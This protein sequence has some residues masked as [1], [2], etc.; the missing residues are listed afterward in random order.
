MSTHLGAS[1]PLP[2]DL[3]ER[4]AEVLEEYLSELEAG[5]Q[6]DREQL[7]TAHPELAEAL[8]ASL[9]GLQF[10]H[11]AVAEMTQ[12]GGLPPILGS[13]SQKQ[14]G[15]YVIQREIGR[16]GMGVV[17]EAQQISLE[18]QVA[19]KVLPLAG[20]LDSRQIT[21]FQK[22][23]RAAAQLHHPNIVPIYAVGCERGVHY[24][25]MQYI[26]G[27][28][29]D[30][31]IAYLRQAQP[32]DANPSGTTRRL[33]FTSGRSG[34][35][36]RAAAELA[37]QVAEALHHAHQYGI[38]HRDIKPS[39]LLLDQEGKVW[40]TD[41]GLARFQTDAGLTAT[42][43]VIGTLRYM[44][45]EQAAGKAALVDERS[46]IYS[47][48][49]TLY[50]L[51]VLRPAFEGSERAE[52]FQRIAR[53]EPRALR[54]VDPAIPLDLETI[55]HKAISKQ[56]EL[57]YNTAQ[58]LADDLRRFIEGRP[59]VA[60]RP[61]LATRGAMWARRHRAAVW[62]AAALLMLGVAGLT[63]ASLVVLNEQRHTK[64]ALARAEAN[65]RQARE[66]VDRLG[67]WPSEQLSSL[68]GAEPVRRELLLQTLTYYEAFLHQAVGD[69]ALEADLARAQWKVGTIHEQLGARDKALEAYRNAE[70]MFRGLA[71]A[72]PSAIHT[73]NLA[74]CLNNIGLLLGQS[75]QSGEAR[76]MFREAIALR[77]QL[78]RD[79]AQRDDERWRAELALTHSNLALLESQLGRNEAAEKE[80][81]VAVGIQQELV[82][83]HPQQPA[84]KAALAL[85][86]N[87][88]SFLYSKTDVGQAEHYCREAIALLKTA[89]AKQR[90]MLSWQNDLALASNNLAALKI[91]QGQAAEAKQAYSEAIALGR[92]LVRRA[93]AVT[94]YRRD[95][96]VS[97][98]NLGRAESR[99]D[100]TAAQAA[101][102]EARTILDDLLADDPAELNCRSDLGGV[103][104]NL[105]M[106]LEQSGQL[107]PALAAY[108]RAIEH[109]RF[110]VEQS[111]DT[112]RFREFLAQQYTNYARALRS[113][114]RLAEADDAARARDRLLNSWNTR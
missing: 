114:G 75:G 107:Q 7:I 65:F 53:E 80:Y 74:L 100:R 22:E 28:S 5:L 33:F 104:N 21:R 81:Q 61:S 55:V 51:L 9:D 85:T 103:L 57:R 82:D 110:A 48:G 96:A 63:A 54:R 77:E 97:L 4:L 99:S 112:E 59:T 70:A 47:L 43:D 106:V 12:S 72:E 87:N 92:Q 27:Q 101:F 6:P 34:E 50:E 46:D 76:R 109:Q 91:R 113:A 64:A 14:L 40:V 24:Y 102:E 16:G 20:L 56:R 52:L 67:M 3:E 44:S 38:I 108:R 58:E 45:P 111:A 41:F 68:P 2:P 26:E 8:R 88:L 84:C 98:N 10:L 71:T 83:R 66:A 36:Y 37:V 78:S 89:I 42:G 105:G 1:H 62:S 49:I 25:A 23:A 15:D 18:R 60:R 79:A 90:T 19:L 35:R 39:N 32:G 13:L 31:A 86:Y 11:R 93:P 94:R 29:V 73:G 17:Y 30:A 95:L 69:P